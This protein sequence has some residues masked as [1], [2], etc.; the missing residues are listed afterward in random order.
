MELQLWLGN[1][2]GLAVLVHEVKVL[3]DVLDVLDGFGDLALGR[4][5]SDVDF[6]VGLLDWT[7]EFLSTITVTLLR[8][9]L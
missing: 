3:G 7:K 5:V 9:V 4:H 1:G 2:I 6:L 8:F